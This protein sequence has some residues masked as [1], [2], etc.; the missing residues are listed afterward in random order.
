M[1]LVE[2]VALAVA[3]EPELVVAMV[4]GGATRVLAGQRCASEL[5][6]RCSLLVACCCGSIG[7]S[8]GPTCCRPRP[9]ASSR[10]TSCAELNAALALGRLLQPRHCWPSRLKRRACGFSANSTR[11]QHSNNKCKFATLA[12][13]Q[14][15]PPANAVSELHSSGVHAESRRFRVRSLKWSAPAPAYRCVCDGYRWGGL[16]RSLA[17]SPAAAAGCCKEPSRA[18]PSGECVAKRMLARPLTRSALVSLLC[19]SLSSGHLMR[20]QCLACALGLESFG[21]GCG[22]DWPA[23][24]GHSGGARASCAVAEFAADSRARSRPARIP[25]FWCPEAQLSSAQRKRASER[26]NLQAA[27]WTVRQFDLI[28]FDSTRFDSVVRCVWL[29]CVARFDRCLSAFAFAMAFA[30]CLLSR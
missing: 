5:A 7:R 10:A 27:S 3:L 23:S 9:Q 16:L 12:L 26:A 2:C 15:S 8:F 22:S 25:F 17:R 28:R 11:S 24:G 13:R 19:G 6:A 30:F 29:R 20:S 1:G 18:E 21:F 14:S 4:S